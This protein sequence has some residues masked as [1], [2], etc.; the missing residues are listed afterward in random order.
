MD[1]LSIMH[2]FPIDYFPPVMNLIDALEDKVDI[3]VSTLQKSNTL[4]EYSSKR[5]KIY[6][7]FKENKK[8]GSLFVLA[9]Y[10]L[11]SLFTLFQLIR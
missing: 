11:F 9:Q 7:R 1:K 4:T 10:I 8:R 5:A 3:S 2:Y 6:R